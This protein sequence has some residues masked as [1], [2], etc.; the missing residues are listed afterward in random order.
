MAKSSDWMPGPR[1]EILAMCRNWINY[2]TAERRTAWGI[3]TDQFTELGTLFAAA[4]A[5]LQ[6]AMDDDERTHVI[7]VQCQA[8]FEALKAKMRYFRDR[9]FK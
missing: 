4:Q 6:K 8:A 2:L 7:T 3:P 5:L 9:F 1:L